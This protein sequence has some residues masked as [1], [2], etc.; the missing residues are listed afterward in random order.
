V[1]RQPSWISLAGVGYKWRGESVRRV[2]R[3]GQVLENSIIHVQPTWISPG[4]DG[5]VER[6]KE[7]KRVLL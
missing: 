4:T 7:V 5:D 2:L 3:I 1:D 6:G